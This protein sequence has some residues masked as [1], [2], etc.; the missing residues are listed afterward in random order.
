ML[1]RQNRAIECLFDA[2]KMVKCGKKWALSEGF[3]T[4]NHDRDVGRVS[5]YEQRFSFS[6]C[7]LLRG[8]FH[9]LGIPV[10]TFSI[11]IIV[12]YISDTE[13]ALLSD[14]FLS[15]FVYTF[16]FHSAVLDLSFSFSSPILLI[17]FLREFLFKF[18]NKFLFLFPHSEYLVIYKRNINFVGYLL[19]LFLASI[20]SFISSL[21]L[22]S[23]FTY[24]P[25]FLL[26]VQL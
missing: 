18:C 9:F 10:I 26:F 15:D 23:W 6:Y 8:P 17:S 3:N 21:F 7:I 20:Y 1:R 19:C 14:M 25:F 12:P 16:T 4:S 13:Y 11:I 2:T 24:L 5:I 22:F